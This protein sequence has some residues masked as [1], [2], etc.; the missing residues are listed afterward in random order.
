M[1]KITA[2]PDC[3]FTLA[4]GTYAIG[5]VA[6]DPDMCAMQ[7]PD[8]DFEFYVGEI[9]EPTVLLDYEEGIDILLL[10][11]GADRFGVRHRTVQIG[12]YGFVGGYGV[13]VSPVA[14]GV[15]YDLTDPFAPESDTAAV[16]TF[17]TDVT[18]TLDGTTIRIGDIV[19][20]AARPGHYEFGGI[21]V[22][23]AEPGLA[24]VLGYDGDA[25]F[26]EHGMRLLIEQGDDRIVA[27][28]ALG[29]PTATA[30][31]DQAENDMLGLLYYSRS[32]LA[33]RIR[34]GVETILKAA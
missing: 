18:V 20:D 33:N 7:H 14:G 4:A 17:D 25:T 9:I 22:D 29:T 8:A 5:G 19:L 23:M 3:T 32:P 6:G 27:L 34:R 10:P 11:F 16:V 26:D 31:A 12:G 21:V 28:R 15:E 13:F 24:E 1:T 30:L 2:N